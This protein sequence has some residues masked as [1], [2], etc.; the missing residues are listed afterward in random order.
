LAKNGKAAA[1]AADDLRLY[2]IQV[3]D[4]AVEILNCFSFDHP[5]LSVTEIAA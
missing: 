2:R 4:R 1:R 5:D 3:I